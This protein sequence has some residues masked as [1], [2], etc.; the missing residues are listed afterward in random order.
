MSDHWDRCQAA[1]ERVEAEEQRKNREVAFREASGKDS[2]ALREF[3]EKYREVDAP[4]AEQARQ[5]ARERYGL[6]PTSPDFLAR[7][8]KV[9]RLGQRDRPVTLCH[10]REGVADVGFSVPISGLDLGLGLL[11]GTPLKGIELAR[12]RQREQESQLGPRIVKLTGARE[13]RFAPSCAR[14]FW[15]LP[16]S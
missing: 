14:V 1:K 9:A 7:Q 10:W 6:P 2:E 16:P 15:Y 13:V 12:Q 5:L 11:A 3:H 4:L 8:K